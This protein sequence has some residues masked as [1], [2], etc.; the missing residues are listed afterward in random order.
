[1][2]AH[3]AEVTNCIMCARACVQSGSAERIAAELVSQNAVTNS[4]TV[5]ATIE[6]YIQPGNML[7]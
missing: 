6:K 3:T 7:Y 2:Y 5:I 4:D 1:M